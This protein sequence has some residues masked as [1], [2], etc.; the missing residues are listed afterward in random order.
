MY[1]A[2]YS[3]CQFPQYLVTQTWRIGPVQARYD[4]L[5]PV[6]LDNS[7]VRE[8]N[9]GGLLHDSGLERVPVRVERP[10]RG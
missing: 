3:G 6:R 4:D 2:R 10:A 9:S 5:S 1:R 7:D 8:L